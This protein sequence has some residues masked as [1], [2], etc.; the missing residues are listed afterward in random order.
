AQQ[1]AATQ[2]AA[3]S[4]Y[5]VT[6]QTSQPTTDQQSPTSPAQ[7]AAPPAINAPPQ[8]PAAPQVPAAFQLNALQQTELDAVL[9]TWQKSSSK[10]NTF[11]CSFERWEYVMAFGPVINGQS[12]PLNKDKG[13]LTYSKPDKGS[14][15]ITEIS[16]YKETP[17]PANQPN[18]PKQGNWVVQKDA[19]GE[20]WVCDGKSIY[21]YRNDQKQVIERPIPPQL[22]GQAIVDGPLPFLFGADAAKLKQRYWM[23][24]D[25]QIQDQNK[26]FLT[27]LPK[28][29]EQAA[30]FSQVDLILDRTLSLPQAMRVTMPNQDR[31]VYMFDLKTA[32]Q[33]ALLNRI[34]QAFFQ[35][36]SI[37]FGYKHVLEETPVAESDQPVQKQPR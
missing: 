5:P 37:P 26:I 16:T 29:Q 22:Q 31:H 19:I 34:Q 14:F 33:N 15:Q 36:P 21:E 6:Q 13:E 9:D 10:I 4:P 25:N 27:A 11:T 3:T 1:G 28:F 2:P 17:P 32:Q 24:V 23:K 20:H 12:A 35:K 30:N 7:P 18:A 8:A